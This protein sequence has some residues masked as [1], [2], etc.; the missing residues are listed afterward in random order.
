MTMR[1]TVHIEARHT[2]VPEQLLTDVAGTLA[3]TGALLH[4][5][6]S[7]CVVLCPE[8]AHLLADAGWSKRDVSAY[9]YEQ[10]YLSRETLDRSGKGRCPAPACGGSPAT[11]RTPSSTTDRTSGATGSTP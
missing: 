11:I 8:H 7:A 4:Q 3:R 6:V 1:S 10:S 5:T 2:S 9:L